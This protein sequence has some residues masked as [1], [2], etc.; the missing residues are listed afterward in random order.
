ML[1]VVWKKDEVDRERTNPMMIRSCVHTCDV[2]GI[3]LIFLPSPLDLSVIR[4]RAR[5]EEADDRSPLRK[6]PNTLDIIDVSPLHWI[7]R[8][9]IRNCVGRA[10]THLP[11]NAQKTKKLNHENQSNT[12]VMI[13]HNRKRNDGI[14]RIHTMAIDI[15]KKR[16]T[17]YTQMP[18][19]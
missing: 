8:D 16:S 6:T 17:E 11:T 1:L 13:E 3:G 15:D 5:K 18:I 2:I 9:G 7:D 12:L 19:A 4:L 10:H 14:G